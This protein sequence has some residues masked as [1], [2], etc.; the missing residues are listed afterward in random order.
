MDDVQ[1][2]ATGSAIAQQLTT[3]PGAP[4]AN[5]ATM[6]P[7]VTPPAVTATN[8]PAVAVNPTA[9]ATLAVVANAPSATPIPAGSRPASYTLQNGEFPFC[10]ARRFNINP[11]DLLAANGLA[12]GDLYYAGQVL[13][14]PQSGGG[15]PGDR[16]LRSHPA[17]YTV[18]TSDETVYS[19]ACAFGD[20]DPALIAQK[21]G[22]SVGT[23]LAAGQTLSI[24]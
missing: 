13:K 24:P 16:M 12:G 6:A 17:S 20:V 14:I 21:N 2:F 22:I 8:T 10:I 9:T 4:I 7:G 23:A 19:I 18:S 15:F 11:D 1:A 5:T 3:S